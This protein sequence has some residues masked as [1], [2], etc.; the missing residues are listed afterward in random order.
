MGHLRWFPSVYE[1]MLSRTKRGNIALGKDIA[2]TVAGLTMVATPLALWMSPNTTVFYT[3]LLVCGAAYFVTIVIARLEKPK[4]AI[5]PVSGSG[6]KVALPDALIE[7]LQKQREL[8]RQ[9]LPEIRSFVQEKL[10]DNKR[11]SEA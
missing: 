5:T 3:T 4:S 8:S 11:D 10:D 7:T 1:L 6:A 9:D 2:M